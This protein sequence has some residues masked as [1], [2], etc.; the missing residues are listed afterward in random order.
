MSKLYSPASI[1]IESDDVEDS[2]ALTSRIEDFVIGTKGTIIKEINI[3]SVVKHILILFLKMS[4]H[5][6]V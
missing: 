4:N 6:F 1:I 5:S 3:N 2:A